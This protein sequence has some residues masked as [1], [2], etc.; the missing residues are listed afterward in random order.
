MTSTFKYLGGGL[1][2]GA[3]VLGFYMLLKEPRIERLKRESNEQAQNIVITS[4]IDMI[5]QNK[6]ITIEEAILIFE[7]AKAGVT[8][9]EFAKSK[10]RNRSGYINAYEEYFIKAKVILIQI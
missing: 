5:L 3:V 7:N 1:I 8:L 6:D 2:G 9:D 4:F 10:Q